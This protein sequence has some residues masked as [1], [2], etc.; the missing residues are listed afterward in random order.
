MTPRSYRWSRVSV[1]RRFLAQRIQQLFSACFGAA[2]LV[3]LLCAPAHS[4]SGAA[5]QLKETISSLGFFVGDWECSGKFDSSGKTIE[6][7]QRFASD[8][9]GSW[10]LFRHDDKAPFNYHALSE[11]GWDKSRKEFVMTVQDSTG[12]LRLFHSSGW[13][14]K[15]LQWDGD[16]LGA[17]GDSGQRF[18][19]ERVDDRHFMVSYLTRK[20]GNW[21]RVDSSTCSKD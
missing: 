17:S 16:T 9:D 2:G 7:H 11:W 8:L 12:G 19:F 5:P 4:Q 6:A 3:M 1:S 21:S 13:S 10:I 15:E 20:A 18:T 14:T